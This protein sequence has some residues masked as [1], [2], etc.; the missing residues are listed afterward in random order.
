MALAYMNRAM[1]RQP[2]STKQKFDALEE[3]NI[4]KKLQKDVILGLKDDIDKIKLDLTKELMTKITAALVEKVLIKLVDKEPI[5]L[6]CDEYYVDNNKLYLG[7]PKLKSGI[8][9]NICDDVKSLYFP[10]HNIEYY[11]GC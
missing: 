11:A 5:L 2:T 6:T 3:Y 10:L 8:L 9:K 1:R 7:N 4:K